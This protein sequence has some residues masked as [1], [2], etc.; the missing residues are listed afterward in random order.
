MAGA[1]FSFTIPTFGYVNTGATLAIGITGST[2]L[3]ISGAQVLTGVGNIVLAVLMSKIV[4]KYGGYEVKYHPK[5][6]FEL[7]LMQL[8]SC[9]FK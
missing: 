5:L 8:N 6:K 9:S 3:T 2:T 4:G 1:S 7:K